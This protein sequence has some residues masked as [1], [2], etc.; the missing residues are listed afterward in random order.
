[1]I[2]SPPFLDKVNYLADN[3]MRAWFLG[4]DVTAETSPL[5]MTPDVGEWRRFMRDVMAE[6]GRILKPGA[7]AVIEVGEV[8]VGGKNRNLEELL[9]ADL[10]LATRGG[11]IVPEEVFINEQ[12]FTKLANCWDV[13]N[14]QKGTNTNR[15]LVFRKTAD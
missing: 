9:L 8:A 4:L 11:R 12:R 6:L 15:C 5:T 10:P 13:S 3:W 1:V 14:N 7:H 2:T